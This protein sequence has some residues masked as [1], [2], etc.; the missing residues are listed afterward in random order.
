M[1][2]SGSLSNLVY[3]DWANIPSRC[4]QVEGNV[5]LPPALRTQCLID[6]LIGKWNRLKIELLANNLLHCAGLNTHCHCKEFRSSDGIQRDVDAVD[7]LTGSATTRRSVRKPSNSLIALVASPFVSRAGEA[8]DARHRGPSEI[9]DYSARR[10]E[11]AWLAHPRSK[12]DR[13]DQDSKLIAVP[14]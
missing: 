7:N 2:H 11:H 3:R 5:Y 1:T 6:A 4:R 12:G 14:S 8:Y 9:R 13:W 10:A